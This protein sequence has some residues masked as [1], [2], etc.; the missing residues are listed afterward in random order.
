MLLAAFMAVTSVGWVHAESVVTSTGGKLTKAILP[1]ECKKTDL[2]TNVSCFANGN[3][4]RIYQGSDGFM[5]VEAK[6]SDGQ[7]DTLKF[8]PGKFSV[9]GGCL[10]NPVNGN[11]SITLESGQVFNLF[12]GGMY[13]NNS[14]NMPAGSGSTNADVSGIASINVTGGS[15]TNLLVGGGRYYAKTNAVDINISTK[16]A[17]ATI[18]VGGYDQGGTTNTLET[19]LDAS[20]NGVKSVKL[21]MNGGEITEGIGCGGGQGYTYTGISDITLK[22]VKVGAFYGVLSNGRADNI[23]ATVTNCTFA[24]LTQWYE[25][26]SVNR[27]TASNIDFTFDGCSFNDLDKINACLGP[28]NGWAD[29]DTNGKVIP[30]VTGKATF[31]F[32]NSKTATPVMQIGQGLETANIDLIGAKAT[33]KKFYKKTDSSDPNDI[34]SSF[35]IGEKKVWNFYGGLLTEEGVTLTQAGEGANKAVLNNMFFANGQ[36]IKIE[37]RSIGEGVKIG[38]EEYDKTLQVYGGGFDPDVK[39]V[40][41]SISLVGGSL[42]SIYGGGKETTVGNTKVIVNG[43][44]V[45]NLIG[46]GRGTNSKSAPYV[47]A[48]VEGKTEIQIDGGTVDYLIPGGYECARSN[49]VDVKIKGLSTKIGNALCG[50]YAPVSMA[51]QTI[52]TLYDESANRVASTTFE[53]TNGTIYGYMFVGGGY[54]YS[55]LK[56]VNATFDGVTLNK[57]LL[58]TGSNGRSDLVTINAKNCKFEKASGQTAVIEIAPLNRGIVKKATMTFDNCTFPTSTSDYYCYLGATYKYDGKSKVELGDVTM[59]FNGGTN[60]PDVG[61]SSGLETA[62]VTL[63]GAK[64]SVAP[65]ASNSNTNVTAFTIGTGKT[66]NLNSGLT[67]AQ[68]CKLE[69]KG[70]LNVAKE[71]IMDAIAVGGTLMA[72]SAMATTADVLTEM[73]KASD[74]KELKNNN[75]SIECKD[76]VIASN[77]TVAKEL[78]K[79]GKVVMVLSFSENTYSIASFQKTLAKITNLPDSVVFGTAPITLAFNLPGTEVSISGSTS[80]IVELKDGVLTI[81]KPG[82]VTFDL[83]VVKDTNGDG[84]IDDKDKK[85]ENFEYDEDAANTQILKVN[86]RKV[87]LTKGLEATTKVYDGNT[88]ITLTKGETLTFSGKLGTD[89][90]GL[91]L[92]ANPTGKLTDAN[93]GENKEVIVTAALA[94]ANGSDSTAYYELAPITFV[95]AKVTPKAATVTATAASRDYGV[96]NPE[97]TATTT[98]LVTGD[99][100]DGI[101][102]FTCTATKESLAN[103][104]DIVPYG[105]TSDNYT[106]TFTKGTLT[107]NAVNPVIE[108][109]EAKT[110]LKSDNSAKE[111]QLKAKLIHAGGAKEITS[112]KFVQ[113]S[114]DVTATL[115]NG[116]YTGKFDVSAGTTYSV[117]ASATADSKTGESKA[118][119]IVVDALTPQVVS[120]G[121]SVLPTMVYGNEM[122]LSA[123]SDQTAATGDYTYSVAEGDPAIIADGKLKATKVG[124][125][126]LTV[127]RAADVAHSAAVATQT[128]EIMPKPITVTVGAI[129]KVYDGTTA[130]ETLPTFTLTGASDDVSVKTSGLTLSFASKNAGESVKV[131]MPELTL[132]GDNAANYTLIQPKNVTGKITKAPLTVQ[133]KDVTRMWNQRYTKYEFEATGLVNDETLSNVYSGVFNVTEDGSVLNLNMPGACPNYAITTVP[134][135]LTVELGTP[136]AVVYGTSDAKKAMIVDEAGY[137]GL[138][139]SEVGEDGYANILDAS[140]KVIGQ[141]LNKISTPATTTTSFK[142]P[143]QTKAAVA[144]WNQETFEG[145]PYGTSYEVTKLDGTWTYESTNT[146]V[147]TISTKTEGNIVCTPVATGKATVLAIS[148]SEVK[149]LNLEVSPAKLTVSAA[150]MDKTYDGTS[151]ATGTLKLTGAEGK[152]VALDLSGITFNFADK[153][154]GEGKIITPS[155]SLI[156]IGSEANNYVLEGTLTGKINQ[157]EVTVGTPLS[158]YYNGKNVM[159]LTDYTSNDRISG[160]IVPI[161]VNFDASTAGEQAITELKMGTTGDAANYKLA[162]SKPTNG[163]ILKSTVVAELPANASSVSNLKSNIKLTIR[164]TGETV[165]SSA[166]AFNPTITS[167]GSGSNTVYYVNGGETVNYSVVYDKNQLGYTAAPTPP[168]GGGDEGDETVTISL[169][170]TTKTL[171]RNEEFV[172]KATVSPSDKTVT[173]SSS[174]PTIASVTA[175][176]NSATVKALKVGTATITAKIGDVTA[177]CEVTVDFATGL[178]EALANTQVYAKQGSIYVNP[179]QPL[180]LTIVNMLGKTVYNARISSYAQI[181]VAN[182]IYIVKLTNAGNTIVT[183]VN[184][185]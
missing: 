96:E 47:Y 57:G 135:T 6:L 74:K 142:A 90:T 60:V 27:G 112:V 106:I 138:K 78:L 185:Y 34:I 71:N 66:W 130:I 4:V 94:A 82:T 134:G 149:I 172:L 164:E 167:E 176:G 182:G 61:I 147:L 104:Y 161:R 91:D 35:T 10:G 54:S 39:I 83:K 166:I 38:T 67:I 101:L 163:N 102:K 14:S 9:Y 124:K 42:L 48:D 119:S 64:A 98:D 125:V 68:D 1:K 7:V 32:V 165:A 121:A 41:T 100:L 23:T 109:V 174:D 50:G 180:Q 29:S 159:E 126:T 154:A 179:I 58:G 33:V 8:L 93:A 19:S 17:I 145:I 139:A 177:T 86:K 132:T 169:D 162:D 183:K 22:D 153:A 146:N 81:K 168:S 158:A 77:E 20:V 136:K 3:P 52:N 128:I 114:T 55:Y 84:V 99:K 15:V 45:Y 105:L 85:D 28:V 123:M 141:S 129:E 131:L 63:N 113:G 62:N 127:S 79:A 117:K 46:G 150:G 156:L 157:K 173:W 44:F 59:T 49:T 40:N 178:E 116:Y 18:Y 16:E 115:D 13:T 133:V 21:T 73:N 87:T 175:N 160:D 170:A 31:K 143:M 120:F 2:E 43:G 118:I 144:N 181:P 36:D 110:V 88:N 12:G 56:E 97:F 108:M 171:P 122:T 75:F 103:T 24:A 107:V 72:D 111:I 76:G 151:L 95:K 148:S 92:A 152:D 155:Q 37:A 65:F 5:V 51:G 26:A 25:F 30:C 11:T 137:T 53:M 89:A 70:T 80:D 184:V 69:N 140:G